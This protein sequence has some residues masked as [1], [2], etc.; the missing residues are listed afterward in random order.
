MTGTDGEFALVKDIGRRLGAALLLVMVVGQAHARSGGISLIRDAEIEHIIRAMSTP[1]WRAADLDP[2]SIRIHIVQD[3]ALNAFVAGGQRIFITTGLLRRTETPGQLIGVIAH[4]TGHISEGHLARIPEAMRNASA[5]AIL[6][7]LLGAAAAVAGSPEAGMAIIAGGQQAA[8]SSILQFSRTQESA[9]DQA[10]VTSLDRAGTSPEGLVGFL[11]ILGDQEKFVPEA[12]DPYLRTHPITRERVAA[13]QTRVTES[14]LK[15]KKD[16]PEQV[17]AL[18]RMRGKLVGYFEGRDTVLMK[19]PVSDTSVP[20][21]YAR[22]HAYYKVGDLPKGL[23][24][25]DALLAANANDAYFNEFKGQMLFEHGRIKEA[26]APTESAVR[27][28]PH[29]PLLRVALAMV[30]IADENPGDTR[31]AIGHLE[32]AIRREPQYS[33]A[34]QQLAIAYGRDGQLGQ[35]AMASA[36][37]F[38]LEGNARDAR[39]QAERAQRMLPTGSPSWLRAQ[40]I[41]DQAGAMAA[42]ERQQR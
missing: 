20:A 21:R 5:Q 31:S 6:S 38:L 9:A 34:W 14:R 19:Y 25:I 13:L 32:E 26:R 35:S 28:A 37:R 15:D 30:L 4:E 40:D 8:Q 24:E 29:E 42:R 1:V 2:D 22:A 41:I 39:G 27:L 7:F 11:R 23:A 10:A 18:E 36:E 17:A 16:P 33:M 12:R 3:N